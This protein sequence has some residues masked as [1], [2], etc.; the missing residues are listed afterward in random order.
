ML[1]QT[2]ETR[3][4]GVRPKGTCSSTACMYRLIEAANTPILLG[5]V[6]YGAST[7]Q[8]GIRGSETMTEQF[9][10]TVDG[11]IENIDYPDRETSRLGLPF[12]FAVILDANRE[13]RE[14]MY[15][16]APIFTRLCRGL[17]SAIPHDNLSMHFRPNPTGEAWILASVEEL[18][19][20]LQKMPEEDREPFQWATLVKAGRTE[21][22][23]RLDFWV[24]VGGPQPYSD[25]YTLSFFTRRHMAVELQKACVE[26]CSSVGI[27]VAPAFLGRH[28]PR[29]T[30]LHRLA[31]WLSR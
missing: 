6:E 5:R 24:F 1:P 19:D 13:G 2:A 14:S 26:A 10:R 16:D 8:R 22:Y 3:K 31:D 9:I 21:C 28:S 12:R 20:R 25:S 4:H 7:S 17:F 15:F 27:A 29:I 18:E 11:Y 23:A 30:I